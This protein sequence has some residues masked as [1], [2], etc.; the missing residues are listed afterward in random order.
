M[1]GRVG[2]NEKRRARGERMGNKRNG[3]VY[4]ML[5]SAM[6]ITWLGER[7]WAGGRRERCEVMI[8]EEYGH[9]SITTSLR[10]EYR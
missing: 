8:A 10:R 6:V 2:G 3:V 1:G 4:R 5:R 9:M 7:K